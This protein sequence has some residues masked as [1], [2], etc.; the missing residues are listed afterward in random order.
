MHPMCL[1]V[2]DLHNSISE[3]LISYDSDSKCNEDKVT[4]AEDLKL[5]FTSNTDKLINTLQISL[6]SIYKKYLKRNESHTSSETKKNQQENVND[7]VADEKCIKLS[8]IETN[9]L[10]QMHCDLVEDINLLNVKKIILLVE[11]LLQNAVTFVESGIFDTRLKSLLLQCNPMLEQL[12]LL[13][14]YF[15]TQQVATH[16]ISCKMLSILLNIFSELGLKGFCTPPE[17]S[18]E[19]DQGDGKENKGG[20]GLTDGEGERDVSERIENEDQLEDAH[21]E[22]MEQEPREDKDCEEEEK[23][24][25][26]SDDFDGKL[27]DL[28]QNPDD[29]SNGSDEDEGDDADK[30]MG[31][32]EEGAEQLDQQIWGEDEDD[33]SK[34]ESKEQG[35]GGE[36]QDTGEQEMG[37]QENE[38]RTNTSNRD[39]K[40]NN[41]GEEE[42]DSKQQKKEIDDMQEPDVNDDQINPYHG[43]LKPP[44]ETEALD[45]PEDMQLD[46][47]DVKEENAEESNPFD[48][49]TMKEDVKPPAEEMNDEKSTEKQEEDTNQKTEQDS[50]DDEGDCELDKN[51]KKTQ[52]KDEEDQMKDDDDTTTKGS[53]MKYDAED[54][55]EP[56]EDNKNDEQNSEDQKTDTAASNYQPSEKIEVEP[57]ETDEQCSIDQAASSMKPQE[58]PND[59][60]KPFDNPDQGKDSGGQSQEENVDSGSKQNN[61]TN[62]T[63]TSKN[64]EQQDVVQKNLKNQA[65]QAN[66]ERSLGDNKDSFE[67]HL[68]T[69]DI[70]DQ[71]NEN[72]SINDESM[73]KAD[74]YRHIKDAMESDKQVMDTATSQQAQSNLVDLEENDKNE[75]ITEDDDVLMDVDSEIAQDLTQE[76]LQAQKLDS[77]DKIKKE[78]NQRKK[79][80]NMNQEID[81]EQIEI[82]GEKILTYNVERVAENTFCTSMDIKED[83]HSETNLDIS[84]IEEIERR[85]QENLLASYEH[86][87]MGSTEWEKLWWR[88]GSQARELCEQLRLILEPTLSAR[89]KGD[90]RTGR[91]INMRKIVPYVASEF[92]KDKIWLRRTMPS[93]REYR[94]IIAID[95]SSS[96]SGNQSTEMACESVALVS[97]ALTLLE[98]GDLSVLSFGEVP[99]IIHPFR[100]QLTSQTG[101]RI[102]NQLTFQQKKSHFAKMLDFAGIMFEENSGQAADLLI[103]VS[104]GCI[105]SENQETVRQAV[106]RLRQAKIFIIFLI[107]DNVKNNCSLVDTRIPLFNDKQQLIGMQWAMDVFPFPFYLF[108]R[109]LS[110]LPSILSDALRQ[111]FDLTTKSV[112]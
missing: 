41:D 22:G 11:D 96:M 31:D 78:Q 35:E 38:D 2:H 5:V 21:K 90:Y 88:T 4:L 61:E 99:K 32:T 68:K 3:A 43:D 23:G 25:E 63:R 94:I 93:K 57:M 12:A 24:I 92:R 111:W 77:N 83:Y 9:H 10:K 13:A 51:T 56:M 42:A 15:L 80:D 62:I 16:R 81:T 98:A 112:M 20:M 66:E 19:I 44:P 54:T 47:G 49:D 108:L 45:L 79:V 46:E 101:S 109:D 104:D 53:E 91:R 33:N 106:R 55:P 27:Q 36:G 18:D 105:S 107:V 39:P 65:S 74:M 6:Q 85:L 95:D 14:Q 28:K 110:S 64:T 69:V 59:N 82:E 89:L 75:E 29:E 37:V 58:L 73:Q 72:D 71:E 48:V 76:E 70:N 84:Q 87:P 50:S 34:E 60:Q 86:Q 1:C 7:A 8:D 67:K 100:E 26:M 40:A 97:Q 52:E 102:I 103:I 17:F 30:Q